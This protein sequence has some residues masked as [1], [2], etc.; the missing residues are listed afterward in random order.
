MKIKKVLLFLL[1]VLFVCGTSVLFVKVCSSEKEEESTIILKLAEIHVD[2][3]PTSLADKE[4]A[5]LVNEKSDGRIT[6][7]VYTDGRLYADEND[8]L[9]ATCN[10]ELDFVRVSCAPLGMRI[11]NLN[12]IQLPFLYR[13]KK[14]Y[15]DVITGPVGKLFLDS[16]EK[17]NIGLVGLCYYDAGARS[18]YL[19]KEIHNADELQGMK[20]RVQM[21]PIMF[22]LFASYGATGI[23]GIP[24][25]EVYE[26]ILSGIVDGGENN[27]PTYQSMGDYLSAPYYIKTEHVRIPDILL[28]SSSTLKKLSE[29]DVEII[30][31][32]AEL[33][34]NFQFQ[35]WAEKEDSALKIIS[36]AA[37]V[38][39]LTD[40]EKES[41]RKKAEPVYEPFREEYGKVIQRILDTK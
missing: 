41:F 39:E 5:R 25:H 36:Q 37:N 9:E 22:S 24:T 12:L 40:E 14:H 16:I 11:S 2:D 33:T 10:G 6:V 26:K 7:E 13:D 1:T 3:Y 15:L 27:I 29:E 38:I 32:C 28:A 8:A 34:Q 20:I 17:E 31:E 30:K 19:K 18:L 4:F 35:K 23:P 21:S